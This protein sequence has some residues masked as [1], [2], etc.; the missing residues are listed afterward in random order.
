MKVVHGFLA[1]GCES[2][3]LITC[4]ASTASCSMQIP[5]CSHDACLQRCHANVG[6]AHV[7]HTPVA[8]LL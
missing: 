5:L 3:L 6:A 4:H 2:V 8:K 1:P 7:V